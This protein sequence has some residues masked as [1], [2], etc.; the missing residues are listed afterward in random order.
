MAKRPH[1]SP[2]DYDKKVRS[3]L[4]KRIEDQ[5]L[6]LIGLAG[7]LDFTAG[8]DKPGISHTE[9]QSAYNGQVAELA[10]DL[11]TDMLRIFTGYKRPGIS[12]DK[13]YSLVL[14]GIKMAAKEAQKNGVTL[15]IQNHHVKSWKLN[16]IDDTVHYSQVFSEDGAWCWFTD[17]RAIYNKGIHDRTYVG[18]VTSKGDITISFYDHQTEE[19]KEV[20]I[21]PG[22]Q[23]DD[24]VNPSLLFLPDGRLMTFF[25]RHNGG[26]YYTRSKY[27]ED[28]SQWEEISYIDL[29]PRLC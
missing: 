8:I 7:Y 13:Q 2:M 18:Y 20:V 27:P 23:Q 11:V 16:S 1:L 29:G 17:P 26:F 3:K 19:I 4:K 9:I 14:E 22:L 6:T 21:Y 25:T 15:A 28:I 5:G 12:Y 10:S 24:H